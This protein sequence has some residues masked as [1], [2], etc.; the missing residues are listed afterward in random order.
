MGHHTLLFGSDYP[1]THQRGRPV[2]AGDDYHWVFPKNLKTEQWGGMARPT[3]IGI[4]SLRALKV[5]AMTLRLT[6]AQIEDIFHNNAVR[7]L[8]L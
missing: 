6:D 4:E 5:A 3:M 2:A 1:V 8:G 7:L